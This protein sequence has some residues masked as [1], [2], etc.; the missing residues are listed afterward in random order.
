MI[1]VHADCMPNPEVSP[2]LCTHGAS[3]Q[4]HG[5]PRWFIPSNS[6]MDEKQMNKKHHSHKKKGK[7]KPGKHEKQQNPKVICCLTSCDV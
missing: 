1:L 6:V 2:H 4:L 5:T 3:A 7:K